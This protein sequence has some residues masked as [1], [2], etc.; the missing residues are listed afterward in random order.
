MET[1]SNPVRFDGDI[2]LNLPSST[3]SK[4]PFLGDLRLSGP[5]AFHGF[6]KECINVVWVPDVA[7]T[8]GNTTGVWHEFEYDHSSSSWKDLNIPKELPNERDGP[9]VSEQFK[10]A[11][12]QL[13]DKKDPTLPNY[14]IDLDKDLPKTTNDHY[15]SNYK[16]IWVSHHRG[17]TSI[18]SA[19]VR[20]SFIADEKLQRKRTQSASEAEFPQRR[21]MDQEHMIDIIVNVFSQIVAVVAL[22]EPAESAVSD[23]LDEVKTSQ[24]KMSYI[25]IMTTNTE[26]VAAE[27]YA[28]HDEF[29]TKFGML[30]VGILELLSAISIISIWEKTV[31][32]IW[33][34]SSVEQGVLIDFANET[35]G[36]SREALTKRYLCFPRLLCYLSMALQGWL[37]WK[38]VDGWFNYLFYLYIIFG[39]LRALDEPVSAVMSTEETLISLQKFCEVDFDKS[40]E[41]LSRSTML[42]EIQV[43]K[44]LGDCS[45]WQ[46]IMLAKWAEQQDP[47][48]AW[49]Y[50]KHKPR[51]DTEN[52]GL[53]ILK[54]NYEE[55][56]QKFAF[57]FRMLKMDDVFPEEG[58]FDHER[59]P[60]NVDYPTYLFKGVYENVPDALDKTWTSNSFTRAINLAAALRKARRWSSSLAVIFQ[61]DKD[62]NE[63]HLF[64]DV[65]LRG[66]AP[67]ALPFKEKNRTISNHLFGV[68]LAVGIFCCVGVGFWYLE[69]KISPKALEIM[70]TCETRYDCS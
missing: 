55:E 57:Y 5:D 4:Q 6:L 42:P 32:Q 46:T 30:Q 43:I 49:D 51:W 59:L 13:K 50:L 15:K 41:L 24:E 66:K 36:N 18:N 64:W 54:A 58:A 19:K 62:E 12:P 10:A 17:F 1:T 60:Y 37:L 65:L 11:H 7:K 40:K 22:F 3:S 14:L 34:Y 45:R 23:L 2:E 69:S 63:P 9:P 53:G 35:E 8:N 38:Y 56:K 26:K 67:S 68:V 61:D 39:A 52:A 21:L 16:M 28:T 29:S 20:T 27:R 25:D 48:V 31:R 70:S 44:R 47:P 33:W